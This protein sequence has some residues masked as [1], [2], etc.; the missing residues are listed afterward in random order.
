MFIFPAAFRF[1][2]WYRVLIDSALILW[3]I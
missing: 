1:A 2:R 3:L